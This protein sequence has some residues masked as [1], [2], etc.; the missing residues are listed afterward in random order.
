MDGQKLTGPNL[1]IF[2]HEF[3]RFPDNFP[4]QFRI[5]GNMLRRPKILY[6]DIVGFFQFIFILSRFQDKCF[7]FLS[8]K[9]KTHFSGFFLYIFVNIFF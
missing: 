5:S 3:A 6:F 9:K 4:N 8:D 2:H 7:V 1:N